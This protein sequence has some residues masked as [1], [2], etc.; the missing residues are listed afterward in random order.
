MLN[1]DQYEQLKPF[2]QDILS[3]EANRT[4]KGNALHTLNTIRQQMGYGA[5]CFNCEGSK[6]AAM[7]DAAGW[8]INYEELNPN[9]T[10]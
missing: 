8:I 3:F 2:R 6:V 9:G 4:Y 7:L 1:K 10:I 5:I